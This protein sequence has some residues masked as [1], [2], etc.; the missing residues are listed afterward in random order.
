[1]GDIFPMEEH[2]SWLSTSTMVSPESIH[3]NKIMQTNYVKDYI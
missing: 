3:T 2:T 1:M